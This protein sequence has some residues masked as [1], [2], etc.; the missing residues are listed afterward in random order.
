MT[1]RSRAHAAPHP[2][3][4]K[5]VTLQSGF[6]SGETYWIED[7]WD[8]IAGKS[9]MDCNGNPACM[10]YALRGDDDPIDDEVVYGKVGP[11][12][13]LIHVRHL[14]LGGENG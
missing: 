3:A 9:W 8:R 14:P 2:L 10:E 4:G 12:G 13:K 11:F 5:T 7:W 1:S 6:Y